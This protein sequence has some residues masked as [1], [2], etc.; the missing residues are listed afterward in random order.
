MSTIYIVEQGAVLKKESRRLVVEK[1]DRILLEIPDFKIER[2]LLFGNIQITTQ[3]MK[4]LLESG[5]ETS[6]FSIHGKLMG[7]LAPIES[8]N[9]ILRMAQYERY[10]DEEF[11]LWLAKILVEGKIK[12][13]KALLLRYMRNH[14]EVD[15]SQ[16]I[17]GLEGCLKELPNK[18]KVSSTVGVEG[19][20]SAIYFECFGKMFRKELQFTTRTR[21]PPLDPVNSLLSLG[22]TLVTNEMFSMVSGL[23]FD[24]YI[25]YLHEINYGR[26]SL[27]L[28]LIEEFRHSIIDR[29]TLEII[30]KE[31]LKIED[32]EEVE[33]GIYLKDEPRKKYFVHYESR[34]QKMF[35]E[36]KSGEKV[37]FRKLFQLQAQKFSHT[38]QEKVPYKP[39][40]VK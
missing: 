39:F 27:A 19:R 12:N 29:L 30:N 24:P 36:E 6:F 20:A 15:F 3:T 37:N 13:A 17:E 26:P 31:V 2:I 28:D 4:F 5:I 34:M 7:R 14:P 18:T 9:I 10:K 11:K 38:L 35:I 8:K 16:A 40:V 1:E 25:G 22:Y 33:G 23:G 32:F 21:Q